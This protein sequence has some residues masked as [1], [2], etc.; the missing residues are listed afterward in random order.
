M[1]RIEG[2]KKYQGQERWTR[3]LDDIIRITDKP[4][5]GKATRIEGEAVMFDLT[6]LLDILRR[7]E[8]GTENDGLRSRSYD[9][10]GGAG[11]SELTA[12]ERAALRGLPDDGE[13]QW[14]TNESGQRVRREDWRRHEQPDPVGK[15]IE[16]CLEALYAAAQA[17]RK[18]EKKL[19]LVLNVDANLKGHQNAVA[20]CTVC[21]RP[22]AGTDRDLL[23]RGRYCGACNK[24]WERADKPREVA[25]TQWAAAR[26]FELDTDGKL[27]SQI[28]KKTFIT[29]DELDSLVASG[30]L[31]A[32][33]A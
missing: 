8:Q 9:G 4:S 24:A 1:A 26:R 23:H 22:V 10:G 15:T 32:K 17:L 13:A 27:W 14:V 29:V 30:A 33:S 11:N 6:M 21:D 16:E 2:T 12:T 7:R 3:E 25:E 5:V 31:P 28:G 20:C 18:F 19:G